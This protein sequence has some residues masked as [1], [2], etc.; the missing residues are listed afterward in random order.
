MFDHNVSVQ[1]RLEQFDI[2]HG[3]DS[4]RID[5]WYVYS[6]GAMR[7]VNPY[8]ALHEPPGNTYECWKIK[9]QY[10]EE[11]FQRAVQ[12]FYDTRDSFLEMAKARL[13]NG[14]P[15][16]S[17]KVVAAQLAE[18]QAEVKKHDKNL[19]IAKMRL[20]AATPA[21]HQSRIRIAA[22][23]KQN[24]EKVIDAITKIKI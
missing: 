17:P 22:E 16:V 8:G 19:S 18:L 5:G 11:L 10:R 12:K 23:N 1:R 24:N 6:D 9:V 20:E 15:A 7:E 3:S 13:R 21:S 4:I 14:D 2:K